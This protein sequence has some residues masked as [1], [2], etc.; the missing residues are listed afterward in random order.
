MS[1][2]DEKKRGAWIG[3]VNLQWLRPSK[4]GKIPG[5]LLST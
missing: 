5:F 3:S 2:S 1:D 4:L